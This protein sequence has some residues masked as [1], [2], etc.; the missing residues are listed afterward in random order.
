MEMRLA[1]ILAIHFLLSSY[2]VTRYAESS[3][4]T[5]VVFRRNYVKTREPMCESIWR[6]TAYEAYNQ[7]IYDFPFSLSLAFQ[8]PLIHF[9]FLY[10]PAHDNGVDWFNYRASKVF[11]LLFLVC[12][13]SYHKLALIINLLTLRRAYQ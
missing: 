4:F 7:Q 11:F 9:V 6:S 5:I 1:I 2:R 13:Q 3:L 10:P 8:D 12:W